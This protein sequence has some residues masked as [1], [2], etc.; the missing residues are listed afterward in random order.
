MNMHRKL[1]ISTSLLILGCNLAPGSAESV[2]VGNKA[3]RLAQEMLIVDTHIDVPYRLRAEWEDVSKA[4][5]GGD[6]DYPRAV[7]GGL[8]AG[9]MSVY[10]PA[11][12]EAEGKSKETA[13]ILLDIVHDLAANAPN[14]FAIALSPNDV[15]AHFERGLISLPIG[16]ENGSPIEGELANVEHFFDRGVRYITLAHGLSNHLADSSYDENKQWHG[17]SDFGIDVI[18]E[19]NRLGIMVDI[20]HLSDDAVHDVLDVS[21]VPV[22]AS[23]SAVRKYTPG[24]ER[25]LNDELIQRL[26]KKGGVVMVSFGSLF[27]TQKAR[28]YHDRRTKAYDEYLLAEQIEGSD[29][30][31]DQFNF[32]YAA[33]IEPYPY[34][35]LDDVLDHYDHII[36]LVGVEH[37]GI[38]SDFDGVG[39][40][41]PPGL[42][43]VDGYPNLIQ[44]F[45]D[46]GYSEADIE[47]LLGTN[48]LRVWTVVERHARTMQEIG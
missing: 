7:A 40:S 6:F 42:K 10:T 29:A 33:N 11:K 9:F 5:S 25:N 12:Y 16:M 22:I 47:K 23:H 31:E 26:A 48:V 3:E 34:A 41:L 13:E 37:V 17:L 39:D 28:D 2:I 8:N 14:K 27:L 24:W 19:M 45:I 46:R 36:A 35:S 43:G 21:A 4:A 44:G 20:S 1:F 15:K 38:G 18:H 30:L 32:K